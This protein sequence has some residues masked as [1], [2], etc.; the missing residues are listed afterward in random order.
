MPT[1]TPATSCIC[2]ETALLS[3]TSAWWAGYLQRDAQAMLDVLL[4][5][6]GEEAI[7]EAQLANELGELAFDYADIQLKDLK[8]SA[9]FHRLAAIMRRHAIVLPADLTMMFK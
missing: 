6:R 4:E 2:R 3:S 9:L 1:P 8:I 5:W 7:E